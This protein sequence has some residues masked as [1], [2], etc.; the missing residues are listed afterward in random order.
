MDAIVDEDMVVCL[1]SN[2]LLVSMIYVTR[3]IGALCGCFFLQQ[4]KN[5]AQWSKAMENFCTGNNNTLKPWCV[6]RRRMFR[7]GPYFIICERRA[8]KGRGYLQE[9]KH[10]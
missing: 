10:I 5:R 2:A 8:R 6:V 7:L 4:R 3:H 1:V 9:E